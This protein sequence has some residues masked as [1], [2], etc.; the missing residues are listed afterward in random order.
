M[1]LFWRVPGPAYAP[2]ALLVRSPVPLFSLHDTQSFSC[3]DIDGPDEVHLRT[4]GQL[5]LKK[6]KARL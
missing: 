5:E 6:G 1:T 3:V 4:I 2:F